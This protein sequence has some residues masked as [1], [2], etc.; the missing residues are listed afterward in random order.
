MITMASMDTLKYAT[1]LMSSG[2]TQDQAEGAAE[3]LAISIQDLLVT[4][5]HLD[6]CVSGLELEFAEID[7]RF[8]EVDFRFSEIGARIQEPKV[9]QFK[10]TISAKAVQA[11]VI[12][13]VIK[14]L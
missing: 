14:L 4:R 6:L 9:E 1:K 10:W 3:T 13:A 5:E 7:V 8:S 12:I 11:G 2:F